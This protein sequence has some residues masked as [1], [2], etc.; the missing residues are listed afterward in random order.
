M[1]WLI[2]RKTKKHKKVRDEI[3]QKVKEFVQ[4]VIVR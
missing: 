1:S 4:P 3:K 2:Q